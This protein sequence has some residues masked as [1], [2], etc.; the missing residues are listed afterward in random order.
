MGGGGVGGLLLLMPLREVEVSHRR[1]VGGVRPFKKSE[2]LCWSTTQGS[3]VRLPFWVPHLI[4][5]PTTI[6]YGIPLLSGSFNVHVALNHALPVT[7]LPAYWFFVTKNKHIA[8]LYRMQLACPRR[9]HFFR[10]SILFLQYSFV[11]VSVYFWNFSSVLFFYVGR[12]VSR[13]VGWS[14]GLLVG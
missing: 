11:L 6:K 3:P 7:S 4:C 2:Q 8:L 13:S 5:Q 10:S 9:W 14:V 1:T 12:S